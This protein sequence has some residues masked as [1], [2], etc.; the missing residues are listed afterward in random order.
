MTVL[1]ALYTV[2]IAPLELLFEVIFTV[3]NRLVGNAGISIICLSIAVNFL[4]LPLYKRADELQAEERD[5]QAKMAYRIKRTKQTFKGDERFFMLQEYYRIN[6]YKPIYALKSSASLL[7]QIPFFIAAYRLLSGMESLKGM[8]FGFITDLGKE[9]A[10]FM[11]GSFPVNILPILMTLINIVTGII[12]TK[13][14]P[15]KSK[16]QVYG[17]ALVFLV[18]LYHSPAGLVFY[19]LL[20]NVFS[21]VKNIF[22]KLKDPKKAVGILLA[23]AGAV[24]LVLTLINHGLDLRQKILLS[25]GCI[26]LSLPLLS[27]YIK[28]KPS[29]KKKAQVSGKN[30]FAFFAGASMMAIFTGFLI[31]TNVINASV[32]EFVDAVQPSNPI[33]YA[34]NSLLLSAGIWVLWGGVFYFFMNQKNRNIA[35]EAIWII[36]GVSVADY[37]LFGT[38][39]GILSSTLQYDITPSFT[40][41][42][43]LINLAAVTVAAV[44]FHIIYKKIPK[45]TNTVI[46]VG[47]VSITA[48]SFLNSAEI[49][50]TYKRYLS[51][52]DPSEEMPEITL[53]KNGQ[54]VVVLMLDRAIGQQVPYIF[55]ERP[56]LK[57]KFD[58]FTYYQ[59]T[60]SYG[61]H[62]VF[63]SPA[64]FGGYDYTPYQMNARSDKLLVDK[65][66]EALKVMPAIFWKNGYDVTV[67]D[68]SMANY[69]LVPDLSIY[70]DYPEFHCYNTE[71]KFNFFEDDTGD[72]GSSQLMSERINEIRNRN[73]FCFSIMKISP[74]FLQETLYDG[75]LYNEASSA[76]GS[77]DKAVY[78]P[79]IVQHMTGL[80]T[81]SGYDYNFIHS[82]PVLTNL[83]GITEADEGTGNTFLLLVNNTTHCPCLLQEPD[84][85]P[86]L[87]V[88]N[89][90][91]DTDWDSRYTLGGSTLNMTTNEQVMHYHVNM[92]AY[93]K[94]GEWFD[95][96]REEGVYDNT[97]IIIVSDHGGD[98][99]QFSVDCNGTDMEGCFPLLMVK[100][101]DSTGF[102]ISDEFMTNADTPAIAFSGL[103]N[104]PVNP[105]T[106]NPVN[107]EQ[108]Y[109][110]PYIFISDDF[111]LD[112]SGSFTFL[113]GSWF[114]FEGDPHV[115]ENWRYLGEG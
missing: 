83:P 90:A 32:A 54:N 50:G 5:I 100:D 51:F 17:L 101:F 70:D 34:V 24:L 35:G 16:I 7:L 103:I 60:V 11:I 27:C 69:S 114:T 87:R 59:N 40:V 80:S 38:D 89:T 81:A 66:N 19:W 15:L 31:P 41:P 42:Q 74:L 39:L 93:L 94:L 97:R 9:D 64:L 45:I 102:S 107:S 86:S 44:L 99:G 62:T 13:G 67:C 68:P 26:L 37:M 76:S 55:N 56:E 79:S 61:A 3:A 28:S 113:P 23:A 91:Y 57:E 21:L 47:I 8:P 109:N 10:M 25:A 92:A 4:V 58:G 111:E 84:Y 29:A 106:G 88:D 49:M 71:G 12:Y 20:N 63:A 98:L 22:Y 78:T 96:L 1:S 52:I 105:F 33:L 82:Y 77:D 95:Y 85:E 36:C 112:Y 73:F 43:Y 18:L 65:H 2:I 104:D 72:S 110:A 108:K 115:P 53:S 46:T 30:S 48:V 6:N 75:G 14:H